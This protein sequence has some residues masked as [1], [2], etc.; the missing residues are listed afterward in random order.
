MAKGG[1]EGK[2]SVPRQYFVDVM[3]GARIS[4]SKCSKEAIL[5]NFE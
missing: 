2:K 1:L 5:E 3:S 4:E